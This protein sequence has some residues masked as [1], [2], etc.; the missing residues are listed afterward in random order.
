MKE[1]ERDIWDDIILR[2]L[3]NSTIS[4]KYFTV[5]CPGSGIPIWMFLYKVHTQEPF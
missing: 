1:L 4:V 3:L 2:N 5:A